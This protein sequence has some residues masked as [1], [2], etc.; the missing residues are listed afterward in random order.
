M[1]FLK[2]NVATNFLNIKKFNAFCF[3]RDEQNV[4]LGKIYGYLGFSETVRAACKLG[5]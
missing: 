3:W 2:L 1:S 5:G 4:I